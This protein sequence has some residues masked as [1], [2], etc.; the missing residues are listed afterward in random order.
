MHQIKELRFRSLL[1]L[2]FTFLFSAMLTRNGTATEIKTAVLPT[3]EL[4]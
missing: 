4:R 1:S 2:V 3:E